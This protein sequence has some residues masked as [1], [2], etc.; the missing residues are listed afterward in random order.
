MQY[1]RS[2][3]TLCIVKRILCKVDLVL[4]GELNEKEETEICVADV[5]TG[6]ERFY[7]KLHSTRSLS[8]KTYISF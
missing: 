8:V 7:S 4:D 2:V 6:E 1:V 3:C 5:R